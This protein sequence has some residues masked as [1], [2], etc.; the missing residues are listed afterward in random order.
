VKG[1]SQVFAA[2]CNKAGWKGAYPASLIG[3]LVIA[4]LIIA[5][6]IVRLL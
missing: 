2:A 6:V 5:I 3:I 1:V 4:V